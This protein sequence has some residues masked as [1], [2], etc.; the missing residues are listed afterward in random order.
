MKNKT[1]FY[2]VILAF[3]YVMIIA[4]G[5]FSLV[6]YDRNLSLRI[7]MP[8]LLVSIAGIIAV[9]KQKEKSCKERYRTKETFPFFLLKIC[10][11]IYEESDTMNN[12]EITRLSK[13]NNESEKETYMNYM[14]SILDSYYIENKDNDNITFNGVN[15]VIENI[16]KVMGE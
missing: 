15:E 13:M 10:Y 3:I 5:L 9:K 8:V 7:S 6:Y 1:S 16:K 2:N 12:E 11:N 14:K 4:A